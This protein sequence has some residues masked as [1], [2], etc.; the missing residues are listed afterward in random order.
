MV[1]HTTAAF[2]RITGLTIRHRCI[3]LATAM[4]RAELEPEKSWNQ[5]QRYEL[6]RD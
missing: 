3:A 6:A 1:R 5:K 4:A 2:Q